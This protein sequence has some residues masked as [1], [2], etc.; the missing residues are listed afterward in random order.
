MHTHLIMAASAA[1]LIAA[2]AAAAQN[3]QPENLSNPLA[4]PENSGT[5]QTN[6][7]QPLEQYRSGA[8]NDVIIRQVDGGRCWIRYVAINSDTGQYRYGDAV[9]APCELSIAEAV[10]A[11]NDVVPGVVTLSE[12]QASAGVGPLARAQGREVART[13]Q[14]VPVAATVPAQDYGY[15]PMRFQ[16][17][18]EEWRAHQDMCDDRYRTYDRTTDMF[19]ATPGHRHFCNLG[20]KAPE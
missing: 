4:A 2:G 15:M 9:E 7:T 10:M 3:R 19:Y 12:L 5:L 13:G 6:S 20:L 16:G 8:Y 17:T 1:A 11:E 18:W 14:G